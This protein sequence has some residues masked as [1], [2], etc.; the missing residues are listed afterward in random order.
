VMLRVVPSGTTAA[1]A[2]DASD[3]FG[4]VMI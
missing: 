2:A 3:P 4:E 1:P